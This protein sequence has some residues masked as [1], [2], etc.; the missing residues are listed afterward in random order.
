[1]TEGVEQVMIDTIE[2]TAEGG[3]RIEI[4]AEAI[5]ES[6]CAWGGAI[7]QP[8]SNGIHLIGTYGGG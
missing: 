4:P 2:R 5:D 6:D 3:V 8:Y 7:A 1:M